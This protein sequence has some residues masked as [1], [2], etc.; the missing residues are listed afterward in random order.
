MTVPKKVQM[1]LTLKVLPTGVLFKT[2][3]QRMTKQENLINWLIIG[4]RQHPESQSGILLF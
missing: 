4:I 2:Q 1:R 3:K